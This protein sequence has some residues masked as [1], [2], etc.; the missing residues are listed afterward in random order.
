MRRVLNPSNSGPR[1][2]IGAND[3]CA[4]L[5]NAHIRIDAHFL[6]HRPARA[7]AHKKNVKKSFDPS[8]RFQSA[9]IVR[10]IPCSAAA[11]DRREKVRSLARPFFHL[12]LSAEYKKQNEKSSRSRRIMRIL[13]VLCARIQ[14]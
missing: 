13:N 7:L 5:H 14:Q 9:D 3:A 12:S 6:I 10:L 2:L 4:I 8:C 11:R 1:A